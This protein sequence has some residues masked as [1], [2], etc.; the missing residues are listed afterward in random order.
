MERHFLKKKLFDLVKGAKGLTVL[1]FG[2]I[3]Q[4][5]EKFE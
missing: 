1:C 2:R 5:V 3:D 4:G